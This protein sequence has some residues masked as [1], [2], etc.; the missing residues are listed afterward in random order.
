[1]KKLTL[2]ALAVP[3]L[4]AA[5]SQDEIVENVQNQQSTELLG[6]VAGDVNFVLSNPSSTRLSWSQQN[7]KEWD[8]DG[9]AFSLFWVGAV[10]SNELDANGN[11]EGVTNALYESEDCGM[12][13]SSNIV[14]E[15][16]HIIVYP[17]DKK[18]TTQKAIA[19]KAGG[20]IQDNT[21]AVGDRSVF[22]SDLLEIVA[23]PEKKEDRV[24]GKIYAG[25]DE[26]VE[27]SVRPLS[28]YLA[29]NLEFVMDKE[30]M[31]DEEVTIEGVQLVVEGPTDDPSDD[32]DGLFAH[33]AN[34]KLSGTYMSMGS[35]ILAGNTIDL[36]V[37]ADAKVSVANN[38]YTANFTLLP[39]VATEIANI[40]ASK[41]IVKTNFG[42]VTID[43]AI[44]VVNP[45]AAVDGNK[46]Q[47]ASTY[48]TSKAVED[49]VKAETEVPLDFTPLFTT[50]SSRA[51]DTE[52]S[53]GSY[54]R[55][56]VREVTVNMAE[57]DING[58]EIKNSD[59]LVK[60]YNVY[61]KLAKNEPVTFNLAPA[62][63]I[64][65]MTPEA[66]AKIN[67]AA[68]ELITLNQGTTNGIKLVAGKDANGAAT[69][70]T[71][72][73]AFT[74]NAQ[75]NEANYNLI[76]AKD[77]GNWALDVNDAALVNAYN[78]FSN[79]GA[80]TISQGATVK[81]DLVKDLANTGDITFSGKV[82][83]PTVLT[84]EGGVSIPAGAEVILDAENN[85]IAGKMT[86]AETGVLKIHNT[87]TFAETAVVDVTGMLLTQNGKTST[88]FGT[89]NVL[90]ETTVQ[91]TNNG[92]ALNNGII[93]VATRACSENIIIGGSYDGYIKWTCDDATTKFT[94]GTYEKIN[95]LVLNKT[96]E[97]DALSKT[98]YLEVAKGKTIQLK[99][100]ISVETLTIGEGSYVTIP[101]SA[102]VELN[103]DL[104][105]NGTVVVNG[106]FTYPTGL[107]TKE[108]YVYWQN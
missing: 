97:F 50:I 49:A 98:R 42:D 63:G 46:Y 103:T 31:G 92:D 5:C 78:S 32:A 68:Y 76:L 10:G 1:M 9:D 94:E 69:L 37:P 66:V 33:E 6:K 105:N 13:K 23:A 16:N 100:T 70:H 48:L 8:K 3:A 24:E 55:T 85:E 14:Y 79:E 30:K 88:N 12:F 25:Y 56:V 39:P 34:L 57:A 52:I 107:V 95:Y 81:A 18:H 108:G 89:I 80:L 73:P 44:N 90:A 58:R 86:I 75:I 53:K 61:T 11:Y 43:D 83:M 71:A 35:V 51:A 96:M 72:V 91:L 99:G 15:G 87:T 2:I 104:V 21:V 36:T 59:D 17:V 40:T 106:V 93:V 102:N 62:G 82:A 19:V 38:K 54:G 22:V 84:G 74:N 27:A 67:D 29:L 20:A 28:S 45:N 65:E 101:A 26:P 77:G 60:A 4:F 47:S 7:V 41:I 64:F